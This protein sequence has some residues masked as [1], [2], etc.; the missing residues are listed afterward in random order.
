MVVGIAGELLDQVTSDD[1]IEFGTMTSQVS[2]FLE[3]CVRGRIN[4]LV[5]GGTGAG[6]TTISQ[7]VT[8]MYDVQQGAIRIDGVDVRELD[9][10]DL[11]LYLH[12]IDS[13][14]I[15]AALFRR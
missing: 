8:R 5:S 4:I 3:C 1:L 2:Q 7:L 9:L 15:T 11:R 12:I 14:N 6:K 13:G 10:T